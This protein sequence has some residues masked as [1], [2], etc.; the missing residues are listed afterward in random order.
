MSGSADGSTTSAR[1]KRGGG[2]GRGF[3]KHAKGSRQMGRLRRTFCENSVLPFK[4]R[5][6]RLVWD[7]KKDGWRHSQKGGGT[8]GLLGNAGEGKPKR[9]EL[10]VT[11]K[12]FRLEGTGVKGGGGFP[13]KTKGPGVRL[14]GERE[15]GSTTLSTCVTMVMNRCVSNFAGDTQAGTV[16]ATARPKMGYRIIKA[17]ATAK[18]NGGR[19]RNKN[20][21]FFMTDKACYKKS[22]GTKT[23]GQACSGGQGLRRRGLVENQRSLAYRNQGGAVS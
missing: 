20:M 11:P 21:F 13:E 23:F 18:E 7:S 8:Q 9:R 14:N 12:R 1:G 5:L 19:R 17:R 16:T 10:F 2:G 4:G 6:R 22:W 3:S 15:G